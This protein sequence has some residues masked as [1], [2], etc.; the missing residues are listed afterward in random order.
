L[1]FAPRRGWLKGYIDLVFFHDGRYYLADWKS[2]RLGAQGAAYGQQALTA[3]M[4]SHHYALQL[5]IYSL[6]LHRYLR[7]RLPSYD[8]ER[9]FGGVFYFFLRGIDPARPDLGIMQQRPTLET[10]E[11]LDAWLTQPL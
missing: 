10:I 9:H 2:N 7:W 1:D 3:A 11:A 4:A 6:A 8:F 5:H